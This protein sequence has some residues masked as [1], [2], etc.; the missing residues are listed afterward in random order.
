[1]MGSM[2]YSAY[3]L[4]YGTVYLELALEDCNE[5]DTYICGQKKICAKQMYALLRFAVHLDV[6]VYE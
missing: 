6:Y 3:F 1:M 4:E 2:L 5:D